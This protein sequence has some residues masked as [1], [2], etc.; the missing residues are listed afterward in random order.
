MSSTPVQPA[1]LRFHALDA[2]RAA[3]LLSGLVVHATLSFLPHYGQTGWPIIDV[4]P[5]H[6]LGL[7][8]YVVHIFRMTTFFLLAGFFARLL[9]VRDGVGAFVRDRLRRVLVPL[10][11]GWMVLFPLTYAVLV[12]TTVRAHRTRPVL[13]GLWPMHLWFLATL[14]LLYALMLA[15]RAAAGILGWTDGKAARRL[16]AIAGVTLRSWYSTP[17]LAA[18]LAAALYLTPRWAMWFGIPTPGLLPGRA[19]LIGYSSAFAMGW[20][21]HRQPDFMQLWTT[22]R[23]GHTSAAV[24]CTIA[25]LTLVGP[26]PLLAYAGHGPATALYA[27]LYSTAAW[28]WTFALIGFAVRHASVPRRAV[29]YLVDASYWSYLVHLP[30]VLALQACVMNWRAH[31][32]VKFTIVVAATVIVAMGSYHLLVRSTRLGRLLNGRRPARAIV[33]AAPEGGGAA[34]PLQP[35]SPPAESGARHVRPTVEPEPFSPPEQFQ[36]SRYSRSDGS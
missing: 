9:V 31:W 2:L 25:G 26:T 4:S 20:L 12:W 33:E 10:V 18:P 11:V 28:N 7:L 22:R 3:A 29:R 27:I 30:V 1:R 8:F 17:L 13:P 23:W 16:D 34:A 19:A 5:S 24:A 36:P 21:V 6:S 15:I 14:L 35:R 32:L